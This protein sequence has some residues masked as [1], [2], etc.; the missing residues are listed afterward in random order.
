MGA[1]CSMDDGFD[2]FAGR[3]VI[4]LGRANVGTA[5]ATAAGNAGA[6]A[7]NAKVIATA[8]VADAAAAQGTAN[9]AVADAADCAD[10]GRCRSGHPQY[11]RAA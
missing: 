8:A 9:T 3:Q 11:R 1:G 7:A 2:G 10:D 5:N 4:T 6:A